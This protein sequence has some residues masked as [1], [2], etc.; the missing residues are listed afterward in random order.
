[1]GYSYAV[2]KYHANQIMNDVNLR[3]IDLIAQVSRG[4]D[5]TLNE[6]SAKTSSDLDIGLEVNVATNTTEG[7]IYVNGVEK[8]ICEIIA[9]DLL[10]EKVEL[11]I[12]GEAYTSGKCGETNKMVFYYDA[13]AEALGG[14]KEDCNGPVSADGT[15]TPCEGGTWN[16]TEEQCMCPNGCPLEAPVSS[17]GFFDCV[18]CPNGGISNGCECSG[19][20]ENYW[21]D[22]WSDSAGYGDLYCR[23]CPEGSTSP[24]G[25]VEE[26]TCSDGKKFIGCK[27]S[28]G[29]SGCFPSTTDSKEVCDF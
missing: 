28:R 9:D 27:Y 22:D 15:C 6:W 10:P 18:I 21:L 3:G 4:G 8:D 16:E 20:P 26:C 29:Y 7:G 1:M 19:C 2:D 23:P 5:L 24:G 17:S 11:V 25:F 14:G 12:D 13:V